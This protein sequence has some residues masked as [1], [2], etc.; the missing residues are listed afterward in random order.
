MILEINYEFLIYMCQ[1]RYYRYLNYIEIEHIAYS[2]EEYGNLTIGVM[3][4]Y[5]YLKRKRYEFLKESDEIGLNSFIEEVNDFLSNCTI[6]T[7]LS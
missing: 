2:Y 7:K 5:S 6:K 4:F 3:N 1:Q